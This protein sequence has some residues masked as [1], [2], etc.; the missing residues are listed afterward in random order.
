MADQWVSPRRAAELLGISERTV[1]RRVKADELQSRLD[2]DGHR[3]IYVQ[4]PV[5]ASDNVSDMLSVVRDQAERQ[6]QIAATTI[7]D[8]KFDSA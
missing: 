7:T 1:W 4:G 8:R 6:L 3:E 2:D 5:T